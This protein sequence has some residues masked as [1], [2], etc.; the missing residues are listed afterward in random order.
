MGKLSNM[1]RSGSTHKRYERSSSQS[2]LK[3]IYN[4][5]LGP[6]HQGLLLIRA[7]R[8]IVLVVFTSESIKVVPISDS[9]LLCRGPIQ[10]RGAKT[11][12]PAKE[13]LGIPAENKEICDQLKAIQSDL[14]QRLDEMIARLLVGTDDRCKLLRRAFACVE[15]T[16]GSSVN[17]NQL[18]LLVGPRA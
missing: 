10:R 1:Q 8:A 13:R 6:T 4:S 7:E 9:Q 18:C 17:S 14:V 5:A 16:S 12:C 15:K 3:T 11:D 2:E